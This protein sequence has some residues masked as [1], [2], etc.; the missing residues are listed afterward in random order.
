MLLPTDRPRN[1]LAR[2]D[3]RA[4]ADVGVLSPCVARREL[5]RALA[6]T[7][8]LTA[9]RMYICFNMCRLLGLPGVNGTAS[10]LPSSSI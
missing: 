8:S 9:G 4:L 1:T 5:P 3:R 2:A 6:D 7:V 10:V